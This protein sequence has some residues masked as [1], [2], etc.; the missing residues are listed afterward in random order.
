MHYL[1][2]PRTVVPAVTI[3]TVVL[4]IWLGWGSMQDPESLW[5]P[6]DLSRYHADIT[7]CMSCHEPFRGP[8]TAKCILCHSE[9]RFAERSMPSA[10]TLHRDIIRQQKNCLAC[11]TEHRGAL[12]QHHLGQDSPLNKLIAKKPINYFAQPACSFFWERRP[13][14][15]RQDL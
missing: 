2:L 15:S 12:A 6:G 5:A 10:A 9:A 3:A 14:V 1:P 7:H 8:V 11:H 4:V 13:P